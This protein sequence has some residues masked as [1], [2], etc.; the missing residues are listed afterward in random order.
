MTPIPLQK[1][2]DKLHLPGN[3]D[4]LEKFLQKHRQNQ[5]KYREKQLLNPASAEVFRR[6]RAETVRK[7]RARKKLSQFKNDNE[8]YKSTSSLHKAVKRVK[9]RIPKSK[10]KAQGIVRV[11]GKELDLPIV[12][13]KL[14]TKRIRKSLIGVV[15]HV[16]SFYES[17]AISRPMP[18]KSDFVNIKNSNG[19]KEQLQM[20]LMTITLAEAFQKFK[21][22][23]PE[24]QISP[25]KFYKLRPKHVVI[26]S[27]TPHN[28]CCCQ[29][30]ENMKFIFD[31]L[32][33]FIRTDVET[34]EDLMI[35]LVCCRDNFSCMSETCQECKNTA[36]D[37]FFLS[38]SHEKLV[39]IQRWELV[40]N[41]MQKKLL[42]DKKV[43]DVIQMLTDALPSYKMHVYLIKSQNEFLRDRK[44]NQSD[45]EA[46]LIVDYSQN[47]SATSQDEIQ[48]AYFSQR[49]IAV[50][51]A[52]VYVG[53]NLAIPYLIVSDDIV[54]SKEQ[55]WCF[56]K[57]ITSDLLKNHPEL[58]IIRVLSD[59]C[60]QQFKNKFTLSNLLFAFEDFGVCMEWHFFPTSHGKSPADG[61]GG[62]F[63]RNV[64]RRVMTRE[65]EVG[66][67]EDFY[68]CA[69]SFAGKTKVFMSLK[70][71]VQLV[72][73]KL[74]N[75]WKQIKTIK[76]TRSFHYFAPSDDTKCIK[77]AISSR[78]DNLKLIKI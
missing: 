58:D 27:K 13:D 20:R 16:N 41:F 17:E 53:R 56:L 24:D 35:K 44:N 28:L 19:A 9:E 2:K 76:G 29:H 14:P 22:L 55:V 33:P 5:K 8:A 10:L 48:S 26:M 15:E 54:H 70:N 46:L 66:N 42:T 37:D 67:A 3:E 52:Y 69:K 4:Q 65:T 50:F 71:E 12:D 47:Y 40:D 78:L 74:N 6:Q 60:A 36:I 77:V 64:Y 75:R 73:E 23:Y 57:M 43:K 61:L 30:C 45:R 39:R 31:S 62:T 21:V 63:K 18:G 51:T 25:S 11:L 34:I 7:Y 68:K 72:K 1:Y 38:S 49:Q 59:G 32:S